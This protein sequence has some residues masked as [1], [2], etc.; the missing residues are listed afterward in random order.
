MKFSESLIW[1]RSTTKG[2][3]QGPA[4]WQTCQPPSYI[5]YSYAF[6]RATTHTAMSTVTGKDGQHM[7]HNPQFS[8]QSPHG[9]ST[10]G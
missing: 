8:L 1:S 4:I 10:L 9:N 7:Q 6:F 3:K 5:C 2:L